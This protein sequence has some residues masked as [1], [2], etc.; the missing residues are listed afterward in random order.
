MRRVALMVTAAALAAGAGCATLG[1]GG[2]QNPIVNLSDVQVKGLGLNGGSLD[3]VLNVYNPNH[4]DL[5]ATRMTYKLYVDTIP[6]G[7]G[8]YDSHFSVPSGDSTAVHLPLSF[9]WSGVGHAAQE[10]M[11]TG[12]VNYRVTGDLTVGSSVGEFTLPY[13]KTGRF[14]SLSGSSR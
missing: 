13:D 9:A 11:N 5:D 8:A 3:I 7:T 4:F 6:F 1:R 10:L 2:F 12:S 14:N